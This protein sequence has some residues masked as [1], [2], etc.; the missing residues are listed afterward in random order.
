MIMEL[1]ID[2]LIKICIN[3]DREFKKNSNNQN[4][5]SK[6]CVIAKEKSYREK[7]VFKIKRKA[8]T[9]TLEYKEKRKEY[10]Q[11]PETISKVKKNRAE[12]IQKNPLLFRA[13]SWF[14]T[15]TSKR[16]KV[17]GVIFDSDYFTIEKLIEMQKDTPNCKC[18]KKVFDYTNFERGYHNTPSLDK[19]I[20]NK[21]YVK[22]N[23]QII[24][25]HC[26]TKK[27]NLTPIELYTIIDYINHYSR[28]EKI[29]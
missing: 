7:S 4:C 1:L 29:I 14:M 17:S 3:C 22:D 24:C 25:N 10:N 8:Y 16:F 28:T 6:E 9:K 15:R 18:C 21:G 12:L 13:R 20:P 19:I 23:V 26:N 27:S 5:C 2:K 11:R